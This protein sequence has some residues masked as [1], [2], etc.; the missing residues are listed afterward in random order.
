MK[1]VVTKPAKIY[2]NRG[3]VRI[4]LMGG[5]EHVVDSTV[6]CVMVATSRASITAKAIRT[7]VGM[8]V[9][10]VFL[11]SNGEPVARIYPTVINRTVTNR[12]R[13]YEAIANGLG[14]AVSRVIVAAKIANQGS[15]LRYIAKSRREDWLRDEAIKLDSISMAANNAASAGELMELEAQA[16]RHYWQ[17]IAQILPSEYGFKGRDQ[18]GAD[19]FNL[20]LNYGY[21]ILRYTVEKALL[22]H[23]LDP[24]AGFLH[25]DRS[26]KPS[27][28]LDV[29]EPF[30]PIVDKALIFSNL[31]VQVVNGYLSY[32][33]RGLVAKVVI[34][35]L[36]SKVY[37]GSK[38]MTASNAIDTFIE[39]LIR[40]LR[41]EVNT[42]HAPHIRWG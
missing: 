7:L 42:L 10:V 3:V 37:L 30:R 8:G 17:V 35:G 14:L 22:I 38:L 21:G 20:M 32:E 24:Y 16:A 40:Y 12:R 13:Q 5:E 4:R 26:G 33:S 9:D 23:G 31:R 18:D 36:Q 6:D 15:L 1:V 2:V 28:T 29:M 34:E 41:R 39:D 27:L 19:V 25:A 11:A